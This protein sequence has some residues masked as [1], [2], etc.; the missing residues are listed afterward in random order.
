MKFSKQDLQYLACDFLD[1]GVTGDGFEVL[2]N[3]LVGVARWAL[4]YRLVFE[5]DEK[6]YETVYRVGATEMQDERPFEH[7]PDEIECVE[8]ERFERT[9]IDY[10]AK[11]S[12]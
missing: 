12:Q 10:R 2:A 8:V 6:L 5:Y 1:G 7:D 9:V 3:H 4:L 11:V